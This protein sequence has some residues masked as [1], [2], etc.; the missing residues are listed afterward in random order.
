MKKVMLL[1]VVLIGMVLVQGCGTIMSGTTKTVHVSSSPNGADFQIVN[2]RLIPIVNGVTPQNV[3]LK[4]NMRYSV[5]FEKENYQDQIV[6]IK[7]GINVWVF[8]NV[9]FGG[10][11]GV[12][13]DAISG[14]SNDI[15]DVHVVLM[16]G[17]NHSRWKF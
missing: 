16:P 11:P 12:I 13:I 5:T 15:K 3:T 9:L 6:P 2:S 1:A 4:R 10:I 7:M 8:G 17:K 14:A